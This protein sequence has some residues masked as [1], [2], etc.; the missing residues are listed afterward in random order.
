MKA[1]LYAISVTPREVDV[2]DTCPVCGNDFT[3]PSASSLV[4]TRLTTDGF[5][6]W[7]DTAQRRPLLAPGEQHH[8]EIDRQ[9]H[10]GL[11]CGGCGHQIAEP[12][13]TE[14]SHARP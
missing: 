2:P 6:S 12:E 1:T 11:H 9:F 7:I 10:I 14:A 5:W 4:L 13:I 8:P 3:S